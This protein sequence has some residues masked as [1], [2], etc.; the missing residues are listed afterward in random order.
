M[1][2]GSLS[3]KE[4]AIYDIIG[5]VRDSLKSQ[6]PLILQDEE[7]RTKKTDKEPGC[8]ANLDAKGR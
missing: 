8:D 7:K 4:A 5:F 2:D 3:D 1:T 6:I